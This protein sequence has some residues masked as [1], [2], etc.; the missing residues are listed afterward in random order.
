MPSQALRRPRSTNEI[1]DDTFT[2]GVIG[3]SSKMLGPLV[4]GGKIVFETAPGCW[5]PMI[6]PTIRG[7]HEVCTPVSIEGANVGDAVA[8][9]VER[10]RIL[11]QAASVGVDK[12]REGCFIGDPYV[13]K[14]CPV[15]KE[16]WPEF[17]VEGIGQ[18]A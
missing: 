12:S 6:T 5:G 14:Q 7:G 16:L 4:D 15:C 13:A 2:N 1:R 10:I 9:R 17:M 11:S 8:L 18:Q 3:P